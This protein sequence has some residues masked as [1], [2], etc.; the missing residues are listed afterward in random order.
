M[1]RLAQIAALILLAPAALLLHAAGTERDF[2]GRWV[3]A[4]PSADAASSDRFLTVVQNASTIRCYASASD[5]AQL[6]WSYALNGDDTKYTFGAESRDSIVKW[7]GAALLVN[8]LVSGPSDYTIMDRWLLSPDRAT[9]TITRQFVRRS[10]QSE[11]ALVYRREGAPAPASVPAAAVSANR[12]ALVTRPAAPTALAEEYL[13]PAGTHILLALRNSI[14]TKHSREGDRVYLETAVPIFANGR[15]VIPKGSFVTGLV[16]Q[17]KQAGIKSKGE[18]YIRFDSLTLPNGVTRDFT[19]RLVN[20][21]SPNGKVDREEG[22]ITGER[23]TGRD[24]KTTAEGAGIGAGVGGIAGG[25]AGAPLKGVG[26]GA[27]AG[28]A[29]GLAGV[30]GKH[31]ADATLP[32]GA[33]VEMV[34][35]RELRYQRSELLR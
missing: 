26:I 25:V 31:K 14:D 22:K 27:A 20:A 17:S 1:A 30:F 13:V 12:P 8:T 29:A 5:G 15:V 16:S 24:V 23:D 28:A 4:S 3:L 19:S 21:E 11:Q 10:G 18:L 9:L 33:T 34:T 6:E 35:D 32:R 7:E 2:S